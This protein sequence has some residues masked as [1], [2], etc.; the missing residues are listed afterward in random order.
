MAVNGGSEVVSGFVLATTEQEPV[1]T[2]GVED[3]TKALDILSLR[4]VPFIQK[5]LLKQTG[6]EGVFERDFRA[7]GEFAEDAGELA[8]QVIRDIVNDVNAEQNV[9]A[10]SE[11][12]SQLNQSIDINS[13]FYPKSYEKYTCEENEE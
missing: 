11:V 1:V 4:K 9:N 3:T 6:D 5:T 7:L 10:D 12:S 8:G 13:V 2:E